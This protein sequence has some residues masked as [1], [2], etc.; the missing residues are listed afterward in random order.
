MFKAKPEVDGDEQR[1]TKQVRERA[2][3]RVRGHRR[4]GFDCAT[5][6]KLPLCRSFAPNVTETSVMHRVT[7][8]GC[9]TCVVDAFHV[10]RLVKA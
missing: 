1:T 6:S 10:G 9:M 4:S 7:M 3:P 5:N 8:A 2:E